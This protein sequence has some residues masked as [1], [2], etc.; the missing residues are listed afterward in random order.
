MYTI[1]STAGL[2]TTADG[3]KAAGRVLYEHLSTQLAR[4]PVGWTITAPSGRLDRG[5]AAQIGP[6]GDEA[7]IRNLSSDIATGLWWA[8]DDS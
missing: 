2:D 3:P 1:I 4:G 5:H 6:A 7:G 8:D